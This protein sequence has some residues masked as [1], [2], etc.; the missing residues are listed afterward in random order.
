MTSPVAC[1]PNPTPKAQAFPWMLN[2]GSWTL[3]VD[4]SEVH[5]APPVSRATDSPALPT[6]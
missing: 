4:L 5:C 6:Q 1:A 3:D 2:V